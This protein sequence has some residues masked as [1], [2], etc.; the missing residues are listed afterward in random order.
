VVCLLTQDLIIFF[1][2]LKWFAS[3]TNI[4]M[5]DSIFLLESLSTLLPKYLT[6]NYAMCFG[7]NELE[8]KQCMMAML[9][10]CAI[11]KT[12]NLDIDELS[13]DSNLKHDLGMTG[14]NQEKLQASIIEMCNGVQINFGRIKTV[15]DVV[16]NVVNQ[17]ADPQSFKTAFT[18]AR[19]NVYRL[20]HGT[21]AGHL[22]I[23]ND[24]KEQQTTTNVA[25]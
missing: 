5:T 17:A 23:N 14:P 16:S 25:C 8:S 4:L 9:V 19:N 7:D 11:A 18:P 24:S 12:F 1:D 10:Y 3:V 21:P 6:W 20:F 2:Y 13:E 22:L 15:Q